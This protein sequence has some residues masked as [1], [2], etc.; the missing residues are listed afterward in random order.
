MN[1]TSTV[2]LSETS[3]GLVDEEGSR[4]MLEE[5]LQEADERRYLAQSSRRAKCTEYTTQSDKETT[6]TT[7]H[8]T[9]V[10]ICPRCGGAIEV[11]QKVYVV[12]ENDVMTTGELSLI[13]N[14]EQICEACYPRL[15]V[16]WPDRVEH[17]H[18]PGKTALSLITREE[19]PAIS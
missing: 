5:A 3:F 18:G 10:A 7:E 11:G 12:G 1:V 2:K 13:K 17:D 4:S 6:M 8:D 9:V 15:E 16:R 14:V 19:A